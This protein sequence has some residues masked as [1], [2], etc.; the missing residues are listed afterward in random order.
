MNRQGFTILEVMIV[1][2]I[3]LLVVS[4]AY[5]LLASQSRLLASQ[6][7]VIQSRDINRRVAT[8]LS[9]EF[10]NVSSVGGDL[11]VIEQDSVVLRSFQSTAT[12]CA[13]SIPFSGA[14]YLGLRNIV[15]P[16]SADSARV[17]SVANDSWSTYNI[18]DMWDA[19]NAWS[20]GNSPVCFW[21]DST[22]TEPR[23][24]VAIKLAGPVDSLAT[25][26]TGA[27]VRI[28][29]RTKYG[30]YPR[31]GRW[32]MGRQIEGGSWENLMGPFLSPANGGLTFSYYDVNDVV[33]T[34]PALV[35]YVELMLQSESTGKVSPN[36]VAGGTRTDSLTMTISL[37]NN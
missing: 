10:R 5:L 25:I 35:S 24:Q 20:A 29:Q 9:S 17:Y 22:I 16:V 11:Y 4:S 37:R 33:T 13:G 1:S 36:G 31:N 30:L 14:R 26:G 21:G 15:G 19:P 7:A 27:N 12:M 6:N 3:S 2:V 18:T 28:F 34:D 8:M 32:Y 23:P